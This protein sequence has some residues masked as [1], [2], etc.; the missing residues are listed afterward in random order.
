MNALE[1]EV[2]GTTWF[3]PVPSEMTQDSTTP[4]ARSLAI[5][6]SRRLCP[7]R[8]TSMREALAKKR[9]PSLFGYVE[10]FSERPPATPC[11]PVRVKTAPIFTLSSPQSSM[12]QHRLPPRQTSVVQLQPWRQAVVAVNCETAGLEVRPAGTRSSSQRT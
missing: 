4:N 9:E 6:R 7:K 2:E 3:V 5:A 1:F 10:G 11:P 8:S 12:P